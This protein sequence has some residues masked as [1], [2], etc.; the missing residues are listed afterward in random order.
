VDIFL[1]KAVR[2]T[3]EPNRP[4]S[5]WGL[6][7]PML[8]GDNHPTAAMAK[9][10]YH[11]PAPPWLLAPALRSCA[12]LA[13]RMDGRLASC[14]AWPLAPPDLDIPAH[15][16]VVGPL[17]LLLVAYRKGHLA[18][19]RLLPQSLRHG[20][21]PGHPPGVACPGLAL[22]LRPFVSGAAAPRSCWLGRAPWREAVARGA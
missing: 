13:C 5:F 7:P 6:E 8:D 11:E 15:A 18:P 20:W 12:G 10:P 4:L 14:G 3:A 19:L 21:T 2:S 16:P 9:G 1:G 22:R 17:R